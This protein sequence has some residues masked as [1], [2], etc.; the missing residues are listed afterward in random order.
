MNEDVLFFESLT[1]KI[2]KETYDLKVSDVY[3]NKCTQITSDSG[4]KYFLKLFKSKYKDIQQE[5]DIQGKA[6]EF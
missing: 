3:G 2:I 5:Y 4:N 6:T 1:R